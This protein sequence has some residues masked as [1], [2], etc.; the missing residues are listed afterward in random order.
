MKPATAIIGIA[1]IAVGVALA[2]SI[3]E[4]LTLRAFAGACIN[5]LAA[6]SPLP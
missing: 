5:A 4:I 2:R 6:G 3:A 1:A